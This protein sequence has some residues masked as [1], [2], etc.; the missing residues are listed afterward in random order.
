MTIKKIK[1]IQYKLAI[2]LISPIDSQKPGPGSG[3]PSGEPAELVDFWQWSCYNL[4]GS[5]RELAV[6][7]LSKAGIGINKS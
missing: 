4:G 3:Q 7:I 2:I 5:Q 1:S 6:G